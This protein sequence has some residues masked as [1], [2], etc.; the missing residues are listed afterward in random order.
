MGSI[1]TYAA[2]RFRESGELTIEMP[3]IPRPTLK[4]LRDEDPMIESIE[5]DNSPEGSV[6]LKLG[7]VCLSSKNSSIH[8]LEYERRLLSNIHVTL[9][10]Q[11]REWLLNHQH[12]FPLLMES[13]E[14]HY[15]DF[16]GIVVVHQALDRRVPYCRRLGKDWA[17]YWHGLTDRFLAFG[18][19]AVAGQQSPL[20]SGW[21]PKKS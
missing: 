13:L 14:T 10:Y 18:R 4:Q 11:H 21:Q 9:G 19:V 5:R 3:A 7:I 1:T 12:R 2:D 15:I 8:G 16:P 20:M 17:G 6:T